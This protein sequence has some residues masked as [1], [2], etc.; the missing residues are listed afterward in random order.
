MSP[1]AKE[2]RRWEEFKRLGGIEL[3][4]HNWK[5]S[6]EPRKREIEK[7]M[8]MVQGSSQSSSEDSEFVSPHTA[9][10]MELLQ[11]ENGLDKKNTN[12]PHEK[13]VYTLVSTLE[14]SLNVAKQHALARFFEREHG[15][16]PVSMSSSSS[17]LQEKTESDQ[18]QDQEHRQRL[19]KQFHQVVG[20]IGSGFTQVAKKLNLREKNNL[21]RKSQSES[22][23]EEEHAPKKNRHPHD[24][25]SVSQTKAK[26]GI[27]SELTEK[28]RQIAAE[29]AKIEKLEAELAQEKAKNK[30]ESE[31]E[32]TEK[33]KQQSEAEKSK[34][35]KSKAEKSKELKLAMAE[36]VEKA[37]IEEKEAERVKQRAQERE[38]PDLEAP[39]EVDPDGDPRDQMGYYD[40]RENV[41]VFTRNKGELIKDIVILSVIVHP[42][43]LVLQLLEQY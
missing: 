39:R 36:K 15:F 11:H 43:V 37:K 2:I 1:E 19:V 3:F 18:D 7:R 24:A 26:T 31:V 21:Q 12:I 23:L 33:K 9:S 27:K 38:F 6:T 22:F 35:E 13:M 32:K 29:N 25:I 20:S 34:A 16:N 5:E 30:A 10:L 41:D 42:Y 40:S 17:M 8:R 28:D 14:N 4:F